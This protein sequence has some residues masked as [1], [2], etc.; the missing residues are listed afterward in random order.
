MDGPTDSYPLLSGAAGYAYWEETSVAGGEEEPPTEEFPL[1]PLTESAL[2]G[3]AMAA[4]PVQRRRGRPKVVVAALGAVILL[5]VGA[6][7]AAAS[8]GSSPPDTA[9]S[10]GSA[11]DARGRGPEGGPAA[12]GRPGGEGSLAAGGGTADGGG[13]AFVAGAFDLASSVGELNLTLGRPGVG[14]VQVSSPPGSGLAPA[15]AVEGTTIRLTTAPTGVAGTG[16]VD[17][18]LDARIAWTIRMSAGVRAA[19]FELGGGTVR[20]VDLGGGA[21]TVQLALP[22]GDRVLPVR[23]SGGVREWSIVTE[24]E[25]PVRVVARSGAGEVTLYGRRQEGIARDTTLTAGD[26]PAPEAPTASGDGPGLDVT[27][28]AGFGSLTVSP[29]AGR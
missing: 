1:V 15:V 14:P 18:V 22:G 27:A 10:A 8:I 23:M 3:T 2:D 4:L 5:G 29:S 17:V 13:P 19:T 12:Q 11:A 24:G 7:V 26:G 25:V 21:D 9:P 20:E 28:A 6:V 16:K